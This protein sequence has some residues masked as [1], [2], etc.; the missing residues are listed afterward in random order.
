MQNYKEIKQNQATRDAL[1]MFACGLLLGFIC[2]L[3]A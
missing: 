1:L 2:G 3:G